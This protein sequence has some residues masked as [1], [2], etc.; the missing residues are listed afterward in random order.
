MDQASPKRARDQ[1]LNLPKRS[2]GRPSPEARAEYEIAL[3]AW[4]DG[5]KAMHEERAE[6]PHNFDVSSRGWCYLLE[7]YGLNKGDFDVAQRLINDCRKSGLLPLDICCE[8]GRRS[9][10]NLED[11]D[12]SDPKVRAAEIVAYANTAEKYYYPHSFW[13]AQEYYIEAMVEKV[14]LKNLFSSVCEP[15][16][17]CDL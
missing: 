1:N 2:P 8:D 17:D 16:S 9:A 7:P 4:C 15:F 6:D 13:D 14:D 3:T 12:G 5:I 10:D 11:L